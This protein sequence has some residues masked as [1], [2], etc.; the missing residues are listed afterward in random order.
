MSLYQGAPEDSDRRQR[1][2][3]ADVV[4]EAQ[5][6]G[7]YRITKDRTG[8]AGGLITLDGLYALAESQDVYVIEP[9]PLVAEA[10][11]AV[12]ALKENCHP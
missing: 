3:L 12:R 7:T 8:P 6:D 10:K 11:K 9:E 2:L 1:T 4:A 5:D